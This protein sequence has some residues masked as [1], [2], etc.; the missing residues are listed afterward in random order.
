MTALRFSIRFVSSYLILLL[1]LVAVEPTQ[2]SS[3][4]IKATARTSAWTLRLIDARAEAIGPSVASSGGDIQIIYECTVV[5]PLAV[6]VSAV[7]AFPAP[8]RLRTKGLLLGSLVLL[9][10]NHI[11]I[12]SLIWVANTLP[13]YFETIHLVAWPSVLVSV[14]ILTWLTWVFHAHTREAIR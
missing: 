5:F 1:L 8:W 3:M 6:F 4:I 2:L 11:R 13:S 12:V 9:V 14:I 7:V 10:V